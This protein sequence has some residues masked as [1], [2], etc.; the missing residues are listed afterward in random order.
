MSARVPR[1]PALL[2]AAFATAAALAAPAALPAEETSFELGNGLRVQLIPAVGIPESPLSRIAVVVLFDLGEQHDPEER[3]GL[4]HLIEHLY[5][6]AAAGEIPARTAE[7]WFARLGGQANAQ[8]GRD[9]TLIAAI[10]PPAALEAELADAAA[11]LAG[12]RVTAPELERELGRLGRELENMYGG[13]LPL[14]AR[15]HAQSAIDP[16][17]GGARKGGD[18]ARLAGI[19]VDELSARIANHYVPARARLIVAGAFDAAAARA[20]IE[21]LFGVIPRREGEALAV[22]GTPAA[23]AGE[24]ISVVPPGAPRGRAVARLWAAPELTGADAAAYLLLGAKFLQVAPGHGVTP[25]FTPIDDPRVFGGV[26]TLGEGETPASGVSRIDRALAAALR[27]EGPLPRQWAER[28]LQ[29]L[30]SLR[31]P[32]TSTIATNPYLVAFGAGRRAQLGLDRAAL[33]SGMAALDEAALRE[34]RER[35]FATERAVTV[36]I[37]PAE[38]PPPPPA[39]EPSGG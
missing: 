20:R 21:A 27:T 13:I 3:P 23:R 24:T 18:A 39:K 5:V 19:G 35:V 37:G 16:L 25:A 7:E 38:A 17:P 11:R 31:P 30:L 29:N 32:T 36:V 1:A 9:Y 15:N 6:T 34:L 14:G 10:A 22:R 12:I 8:T 4:A 33:V 2:A 26:V 28:S